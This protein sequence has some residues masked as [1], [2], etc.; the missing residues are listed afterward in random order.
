M[1]AWAVGLAVAATVAAAS[2][3]WACVPQPIIASIQPRSSGAAGSEVTVLGENF[4]PGVV[5]L[6]WNGADGTLLGKAAGPAFAQA[7]TIPPAEDGL[8]VIIALTRDRGGGVSGTAR[9]SF[10]VTGGAPAASAASRAADPRP[11][12]SNVTTAPVLLAGAVVGAS[13]V[14]VASRLRRRSSVAAQG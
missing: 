3:A 1:N 6:R 2:S 12:P 10:A 11:A 7:V 14:W 5:E 4:D 13:A 9:A 8:Y